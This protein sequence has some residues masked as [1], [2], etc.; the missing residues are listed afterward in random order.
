MKMQGGGRRRKGMRANKGA[1]L[2]AL[3][4]TKAAACETALL[5]FITACFF[6]AAFRSPIAD[7]RKAEAAREGEQRE[8]LMRGPHNLFEIFKKF[9][10]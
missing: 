1:I 8:G 9:L 4:W 5:F 7:G 10:N 6:I 3:P 2:P